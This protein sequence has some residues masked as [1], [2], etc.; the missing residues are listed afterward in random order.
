VH[1]EPQ[2]F[3]LHFAGG[4]CYS[5]HFLKKHF[6]PEI[7]FIPLE[8]PGRGKRMLEPFLTER[9]LAVQD[10]SEQIRQ[11][12]NAQP[13]VIY[14]H[15]MGASLGLEVAAA[16][17]KTGDLPSALVVSGKAWPITGTNH[18]RYLASEHDFKEG[19]RTLGRTPENVLENKKLFDYFSKAM[20]ADFE[21]VEKK[22]IAGLE[23]LRLPFPII[24]VMGHMDEGVAEIEQWQRLSSKKGHSEILPGGHFFIHDHP[25]RLAGI[26]KQGFFTHEEMKD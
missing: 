5:F 16:F 11:K 4:N 19:L 10:Y 2:I 7:Q 21:I 20:R 12:R 1:T 25:E 26:M 13:F 6:E 23:N 3:L 22:K 24:A 8:L 18:Q 17:V 15:S 14:G 9:E